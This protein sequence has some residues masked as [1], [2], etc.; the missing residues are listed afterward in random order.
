M[1]RR[2]FDPYASFRFVVEINNIQV[3]GFSDCTGLQMEVKAFEYKE[4]GRNNTILKFPEHASY[5]NV[6][7]KRGL[8]DST[9]MID[10]QL[11]VA[12]GSFNTRPRRTRFAIILKDEKGDDV[13][14]WNLVRAYPVKWTGPDLKANSSE[15]AVESLEIA[16]EGIQAG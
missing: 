11:D 15:I 4:G 16:H 12:A 13:K 6:T 3:A 14:R 1:P 10:W 5:G 8:T 9:V 7:L 2:D